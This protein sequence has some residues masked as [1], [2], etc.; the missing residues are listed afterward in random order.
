MGY[1]LFASIGR[2][3]AGRSCNVVAS[4]GL[5]T[6]ALRA[7]TESGV[8]VQCL[9]Y[10]GP[11]LVAYAAGMAVEAPVVLAGYSSF[12]LNEAFEVWRRVI[13]PQKLPLT[14]LGLAGLS[15]D[16]RGQPWQSLED[17]ALARLVSGLAMFVPSS[18]QA[19]CG[20][21]AVPGEAGPLYMRLSPELP[22]QNPCE[23]IPPLGR[24][25]SLIAC[26][27]MVFIAEKARRM[28]QAQ[29]YDLGVI[30][31]PDL[32]YLP[33]GLLTQLARFGGPAVI[34]E[35]AVGPGG[36]GEA[37]AALMSRVHP[38]PIYNMT[39]EGPGTAGAAQE[40]LDYYGLTASRLAS[41][42]AQ[43]CSRRRLNYGNCDE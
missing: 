9:P 6:E 38:L 1:E 19:A 25:G 43:A 28:L 27:I 15:A 39:V 41:L 12:L 42:A 23:G 29:G 8:S 4:E 11:D 35:E 18:V 33:E 21:L 22:E 24:D 7:L 16:F 14:L 34:A 20:R 26:G 40:V 5:K 30:D 3:L 2:S 32:C 37:V 17:I 36:L 13:V 10:D 31:C